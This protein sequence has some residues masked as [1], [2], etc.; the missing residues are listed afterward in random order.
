MDL[1]YVGSFS[2]LAC[3][4]R[5]TGWLILYRIKPGQAVASRL[6]F[7]FREIFQAYCAP[8]ELSTDSGPPLSAYS[9]QQFQKY[10]A[11]KQRISSVA[12][13]QSNRRA[14]LA[15]KTAKRFIS[16]C[17]GHQCSL[18]NDMA[19]Q[20]TLQ[21]RNTPI[22][23][24]GL[25]PAHFLL[26]RRLRDHIPSHPHLNKPHPEWIAAA[27]KREKTLSKRNEDL[28]KRYNHTAYALSPLRKGDTVST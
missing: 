15:V 4:D 10:W 19:A 11:V 23:R 27:Q 6:I 18:D 2:Y 25:L 20:A 3:A 5:L 22:Q 7:I 17:K 13:P 1:F 21:Y 26:Q 9:F 16:D 28:L 12:Y 8:E 14:E 24:I